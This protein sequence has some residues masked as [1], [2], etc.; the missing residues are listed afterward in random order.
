MPRWIDDLYPD[1]T[2]SRARPVTAETVLIFDGRIEKDEYRWITKRYAEILSDASIEERIKVNKVG[3][4]KLAYETKECTEGW[5]TVF[6][7][8]VDPDLIPELEKMFRTDK[9]I[10]KYM[11]TVDDYKAFDLRDAQG[12]WF[13]IRYP[14]EQKKPVDVFDLIFGF[15]EEE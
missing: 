5:Y 13:K 2:T 9:S 15:N 8:I 14:D 6:T 12:D 3:K 4:K 1:S 10:I 11:T 7:Y